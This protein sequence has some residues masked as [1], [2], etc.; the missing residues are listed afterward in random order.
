MKQ[1]LLQKQAVNDLD[2]DNNKYNNIF[3][4]TNDIHKN[5]LNIQLSNVSNFVLALQS[6]YLTLLLQ[7]TTTLLLQLTA[8]LSL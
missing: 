5:S 3:N 8:T 6:L 4:K 7:P 1:L 2:G